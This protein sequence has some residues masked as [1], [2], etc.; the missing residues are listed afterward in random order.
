MFA[1]IVGVLI[2][3]RLGYCLFYDASMFYTFTNE[4]PWWKLLA[5]QDGGMASHGGMIGVAVAFMIWGK[6]N[7]IATLYLF[8]IG[9]MFA[10]PGLFFGRIANFVNGELWGRA[11]PQEA[12][13][14]PPAWS[15]K[16]PTEITNVWLQNPEHHYD[17]LTQLEPLQSTVVG[18][19][20][21][22]QSI[23]NEIYAG[24][25]LVIET[26][27]PL[28]TAWYPSQLFQAV[29]EG[30]LLF[31]ALIVI[32]WKPK[33]PGIIA[34]NFL[35]L[36]GIARIATEAFRQPDEG[37]SLLIGLSRGQVLSVIMIIFGVALLIHTSRRKSKK[38]GGFKLAAACTKTT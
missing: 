32:W 21:F 5:I 8:D 14:N 16:Y 7:N 29:A 28:L 1:A 18:G 24:N 38:Y 17:K 25:S 27:Q 10:T 9:A 19:N 23:V 6:R 36:Y 30:P 2:G 37:V 26:V 3:G 35:L 11:L 12:Q 34:S 4:F 31:I 22:H 13:I 33:K 15:V 20:S